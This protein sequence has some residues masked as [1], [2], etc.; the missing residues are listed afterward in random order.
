MEEGEETVRIRFGVR[1]SSN[2]GGV[3]VSTMLSFA[4]FVG[5]STPSE[6]ADSRYTPPARSK[7][8]PEL[9][10]SVAAA[11]GISREGTARD[12]VGS[13]SEWE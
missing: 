5:V 2:E 13:C 7:E 11:D 10:L 9:V 1:G 4:A 8:W 3:G 12:E 6:V